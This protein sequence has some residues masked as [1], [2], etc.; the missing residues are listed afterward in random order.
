MRAAQHLDFRQRDNAVKLWVVW[1]R[2][3]PGSSWTNLPNREELTTCFY[4]LLLSVTSAL[5]KCSQRLPREMGSAC[6]HQGQCCR[7][8]TEL[9]SDLCRTTH[10]R[11]L[12]DTMLRRAPRLT[13][14]LSHHRT[15]RGKQTL[16]LLHQKRL[17]I[18]LR[19][20]VLNAPAVITL[21]LR[22]TDVQRMSAYLGVRKLRQ[23]HLSNSS[24]RRSINRIQIHHRNAVVQ[25]RAGSI[26]VQQQHH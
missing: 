18:W 13:S 10:H 19:E 5:S 8:T 21:R 1:R 2:C 7:R 16:Y 3:P 24:Q 15:H 26:F 6:R 23:R 17:Q 20:G 12:T 14:P 22:E 9:Y 4:H 25:S 11:S